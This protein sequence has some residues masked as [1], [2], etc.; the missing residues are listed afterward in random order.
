MVSLSVVQA[1][2]SL[3]ASSLPPGLVAVFVG[4]TS[5]IGEATLKQFVKHTLKPRAYFVGRSQTAGNR[6]VDEC[7]ALNPVGEYT[8][9]K[10]DVSLIRVVDE[11]CENIKVKERALNVLC[12]SMGVTSMDRRGKCRARVF[13]EDSSAHVGTR[14]Y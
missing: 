6:I 8:F 5:G 9:I 7:K 1:S 14:L 2:N 3:I 13:A 11:V 10:A 12:L 4:A